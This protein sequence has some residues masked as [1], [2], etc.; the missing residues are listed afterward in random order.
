MS[1]KEIYELYDRLKDLE[2]RVDRLERTLNT[3]PNFGTVKN[4][5]FGNKYNSLQPGLIAQHAEMYRVYQRNS[6]LTK[7]VIFLCSSTAA[8]LIGGAIWLARTLNAGGF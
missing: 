7:A 5:L 6:I 3:P 2:A 4:E 1:D 8:T